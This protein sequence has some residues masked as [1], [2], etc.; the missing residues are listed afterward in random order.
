MKGKRSNIDRAL[1]IKNNSSI[2]INEKKVNDKQVRQSKGGHKF[3]YFIIL[4]AI[5]YYQKDYIM[6]VF[7]LKS[8]ADKEVVIQDN[9][10]E[11]IPAG[12]KG[13]I[14]KIRFKNLNKSEDFIYVNNEKVRADYLSSINVIHGADL[15][16]RIERRKSKHV[17]FKINLTKGEIYNYR[18]PSSE[19]MAY[20]Y[21]KTS[22]A[23][24][25]GTLYLDVFDEKRVVDLPI[26]SA[27]GIALPVKI[28]KLK[29]SSKKSYELFYKKDREDFQRVIKFA[30]SENET[31]NLCDKL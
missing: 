20:G 6:L 7:K 10:I 13:H 27:K 19:Y 29:R 30:L 18:I 5:S 3:I 12:R 31:V 21:I 11:K 26:L 14:S 2:A 1:M 25:T 24:I 28:D 8:P 15:N 23:C 4:L 9:I 17:V 22:R 16:V